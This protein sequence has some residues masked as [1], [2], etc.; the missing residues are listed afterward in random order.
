[1]SYDEKRHAAPHREDDT[2][3]VEKGGVTSQTRSVNKQYAFDPHDLDKVQRRLTQRHV[4]MY[5]VHIGFESI[6]SSSPRTGL[7]L[8]VQSVLG[9]F[10]ALVVH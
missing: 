9:Y 6:L 4:Q 7:P 10:L 1:M 3:S 8:R 2:A 5:V